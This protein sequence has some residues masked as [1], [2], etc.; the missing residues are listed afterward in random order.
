MHVG[1][2]YT[3]ESPAVNGRC[4][5][6]GQRMDLLKYQRLSILIHVVKPQFVILS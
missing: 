5:S 4:T 2:V 1:G 3:V 6:I